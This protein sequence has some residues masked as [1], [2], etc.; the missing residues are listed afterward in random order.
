M[1]VRSHPRA[2]AV[3]RLT[4][5]RSRTPKLGGSLNFH[6]I[7]SFL[8]SCQHPESVQPITD[9]EQQRQA[10]QSAGFRYAASANLLMALFLLACVLGAALM[11]FAL[12]GKA[13]LWPLLLFGAAFFVIRT[14]L[15]DVQR[16]LVLSRKR[17]AWFQDALNRNDPAWQGEDHDSERFASLTPLGEDQLGLFGAGSLFDRISTCKTE[18]GRTR[19]AAWLASPASP[20]VVRDRQTAISE[21][22]G[23]LSFRT[24]CAAAA[25]NFSDLG[26]LEILSNW[27]A[28]PETMP[29]RKARIPLLVLAPLLTLAVGISFWVG[30]LSGAVGLSLTALAGAFHFWLGAG[31]GSSLGT[32]SD[33]AA[34]LIGLDIQTVTRLVEVVAASN[35]TSGLLA[36]TRTAILANFVDSGAAEALRQ[37]SILLSLAGSEALWLVSTFFLLPQLAAIRLHEWKTSYGVAAKQGLDAIADLEALVALG[38]YAAEHPTRVYPEIM[39]S[40]AGAPVFRAQALGHP[41]MD[42]AVCVR[43]DVQLEGKSRYWVISGSNMGGKSTLLRAIGANLSLA[44]AGAPVNASALET[45][46]GS[47]AAS[48]TV[49]D[50]LGQGQSKFSAEVTLLKKILDFAAASPGCVVLL[51]EILSGANSRDRR[52]AALEI[53]RRLSSAKTLGIVTTHD[54]AV[55]DELLALP[56]FQPKHFTAEDTLEGLQFDY[57]IRDGIVPGSNGLAVLRMLGIDIQQQPS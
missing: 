30:W 56:S 25:T 31:T 33:G 47:V 7:D 52:I 1:C 24:D 19:L 28:Q 32:L 11:G 40:Q 4:Q 48:I 17:E 44:W 53:V 13:L 41:L 49:S 22:S 54:L 20:A 42:D 18:P 51:D 16:K 3:T 57:K 37:G 46:T 26:R 12:S 14:R 27:L 35:W 36:E 5:S 23:H 43:N 39:E 9:Y 55:S 50:S 6:L 38:T 21:L 34:H 8:P 10:A 2:C 29:S 15:T 45:S